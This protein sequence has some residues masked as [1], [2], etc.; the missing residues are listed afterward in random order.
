[1]AIYN[2]VITE[3]NK[4]FTKEHGRHWGIKDTFDNVFLPGYF[5]DGK[6]RLKKNYR[7]KCIVKALWEFPELHD[8]KE[9]SKEEA[10]KYVPAC[11]KVFE[12]FRNGYV[13]KYF[14]TWE[15]MEKHYEEVEKANE[16]R[17]NAREW[18]ETKIS[19]MN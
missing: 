2:K 11:V 6:Q 19:L 14:G 13:E 4:I 5:G 18:V 9:I 8:V 15:K 12:D 10:K 17:R 3:V 1:M 16:A 7:Q